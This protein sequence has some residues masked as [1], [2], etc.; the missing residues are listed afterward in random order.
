MTLAAFAMYLFFNISCV[1]LVI[2]GI[3]CGILICEFYERRELKNHAS[4]PS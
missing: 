1:V 4:D 2:M 3:V